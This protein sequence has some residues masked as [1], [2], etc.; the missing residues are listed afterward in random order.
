MMSLEPEKLQHLVQDILATQPQEIGCDTCFAK[1]DLYVEMVLTGKDAALAMP[2]VHA[3]LE[4][5]AACREEFE[6]LLSAMQ[7]FFEPS[8]APSVTS[9]SQSG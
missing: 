2:L 6:A 9:R 1:L 4:R 8:V 7:F 3:H 5:C